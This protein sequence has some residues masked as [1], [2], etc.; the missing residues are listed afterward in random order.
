VI[1]TVLACVCYLAHSQ[2]VEGPARLGNPFTKPTDL[3]ATLINDNT[4]VLYFSRI[5]VAARVPS[6]ATLLNIT[7]M[8]LVSTTYDLTGVQIDVGVWASAQ[9][10]A[11][12]NAGTGDAPVGTVLRFFQ[13]FQIGAPGVHERFD[14]WEL[15]VA[16]ARGIYWIGIS[17]PA[18][19]NLS[20]VQV[21]G[22]AQVSPLASLPDVTISG[23][24]DIGT[25]FADTPSVW[26][27][28]TYNLAFYLTGFW[29]GPA[30]V[31]LTP[32]VS[33]S[34][35]ISVSPSNC[36]SPTPSPNASAQPELKFFPK[37]RGYNAASLLMPSVLALLLAAVFAL[38]TPK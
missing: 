19:K 30:N 9:R 25:L 24:L 38:G 6:G 23:T 32:S 10:T 8:G 28:A 26:D 34:P 12:P 18:F 22:G 14:M 31:V 5:D 20:V 13:N 17:V 36:P 3:G 2:S 11:G 4:S 33:P 27:G 21:I 15:P 1:A 29:S 7:G 37:N 16:P 35:S